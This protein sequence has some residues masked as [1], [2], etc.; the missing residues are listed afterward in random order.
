MFFSFMA[1]RLLLIMSE[2]GLKGKQIAPSAKKVKEKTEMGQIFGLVRRLCLYYGFGCF[3][4]AQSGCSIPF[5][6]FATLFDLHPFYGGRTRRKTWLAI[7]GKATGG[8]IVITASRLNTRIKTTRAHTLPVII[9]I[10]RYRQDD[11][12]K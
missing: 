8:I 12:G 4:R 11:P 10:W 7:C 5:I 1:C 6:G 3:F 2:E 9:A